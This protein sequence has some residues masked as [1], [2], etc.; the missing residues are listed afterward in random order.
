MVPPFGIEWRLKIIEGEF[1]PIS[2]WFLTLGGA[3]KRSGSPFSP[4]TLSFWQVA[5][6][7][8]GSLLPYFLF[9]EALLLI[10]VTIFGCP[11]SFSSLILSHFWAIVIFSHL[12][13][14]IQIFGGILC[15][16]VFLDNL[17]PF[18]SS[19]SSLGGQG[20]KL[21]CFGKVYGNFF[22]IDYVSFR[23]CSKEFHTFSW[24]KFMISLL[25]IW[26]SPSFSCVANILQVA[27]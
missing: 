19:N 26:I 11:C 17:L 6:M 8:L 15:P 16:I 9:K 2:I 20:S 24:L 1:L 22:A 13:Y 12:A 18:S 10:W 14:L 3:P 7:H 27:R 4:P 25:I 21:L 5:C 23:F